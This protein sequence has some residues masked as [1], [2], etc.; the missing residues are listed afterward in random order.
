MLVELRDVEVYVEPDDILKQALQDGDIS[1]RDTLS[2]CEDEV[3]MQDMLEE[4]APDGDDI[5]QYCN[6][7]KIE[8]EY[9]FEEIVKS[10][11]VLTQKERA[12]LMWFIIGI[13]DDEIRMVITTE[14]VIPKMNELIRVRSNESD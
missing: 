9:D 1:V 4:L 3:G 5:Q 7:K 12:S 10:L 6:R 2:L 8:L 13:N 14:L 11:K